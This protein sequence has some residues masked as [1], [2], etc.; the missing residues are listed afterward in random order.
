M[1]VY[2]KLIN[3]PYERKGKCIYN[4]ETGIISEG[5]ILIYSQYIYS[6]VIPMALALEEMGFTKYGSN[7]LFKTPPTNA[8]DVRT[9][10]PPTTN[11]DFKPAKYIMIT[12]NAQLSPNNN[13]DVKAITNIDNIYDEIR[14]QDISGEKIK[15]VLISESGSEGIDF[16]AIRQV[17]IL[18]PWYNINRIEQVIGRAVRNL[19]HKWLPLNKRNVQ[20]FMHGTYLPDKKTETADVYIYRKAELKA[21]QIGIVTRILKENAV[22]CILNQGQ[23]NFTQEK[24]QTKLDIIL[25]TR[26]TIEYQVGDSPY[27]M[28]CDYMESC[29]YKCN[30]EVPSKLNTYTYSETFMNTNKDTIINRIKALFKERL[31][32]KKMNLM[33][34]INPYEKYSRLQIFA[35]LTYMIENKMMI[36]DNY[37]RSG[38]LINIGDYYLFQPDEQIEQRLSLYERERPLYNAPDKI[39]IIRDVNDINLNLKPQIKQPLLEEDM[40]SNSIIQSIYTKFEHAMKVSRSN[41]YEIERV[42]AG[43]EMWVEKYAIMGIVLYNLNKFNILINQKE[44]IHE[45]MLEQLLIEHIID[46]LLPD[47]KL[48]LLFSILK[49]QNENAFLMK[50]KRYCEELLI[51]IPGEIERFGYI[52]YKKKT[53]YYI[54]KKDRNTQK[55]EYT[56]VNYSKAD[57]SDAQKMIT[58][59][60]FDNQQYSSKQ[61]N[62]LVG[63]IDIKDQ[64][65]MVFKTKTTVKQPDVKRTPTG[66]ICNKSVN[67]TIMKEML[68]E[69]V[70]SP[71]YEI[72]DTEKLSLHYYNILEVTDTNVNLKYTNENELCYLCEMILRYYEKTN[73]RDKIWFL[74]YEIQNFIQFVNMKPVNKKI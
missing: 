36:K 5:I 46:N 38:Y 54:F 6:G 30:S 51:H 74:N 59:Y 22:D 31:F 41:I 3:M 2:L 70:D 4:K 66:R 49:I 40:Y 50:V 55:W 15:V 12:G 29:D 52:S 60:A 48:Q 68:N 11:S 25:S 72:H 53:Q 17:H 7:S 34:Y 21:K 39:M 13:N 24:L 71:I 35:A 64:N 56:E 28:T 26:E 19:S 67:K 69:I 10:Q 14:Q 42:H 57:Y 63:F 32:Y 37:D 58:Q 44:P 73:Y 33:K 45:N 27:S 65:I 20:I 16:K 23:T 8:V 9:M 43:E 47:E 1:I 62:S 61:F 18:E